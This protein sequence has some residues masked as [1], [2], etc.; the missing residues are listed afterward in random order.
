MARGHRFHLD[1]DGHSVS[2]E[3]TGP[4]GPVEVLVDGKVVALCPGRRRGVAVLAAEL[5]GDPPRP[6][7]VRVEDLGEV[8]FC[9]L[10][11]SGERYLMPRV[12]LVPHGGPPGRA[13]PRPLRRLRAWLRRR[14][15]RAAR[16]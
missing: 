15:R 9:V 16:R 12:P 4:S 11:T 5:P 10:E 1:Q 13:A 3:L 7:T 2:V 8:P 14:L 6:I